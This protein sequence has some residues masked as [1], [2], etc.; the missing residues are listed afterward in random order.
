MQGIYITAAITT[1]LA[2]SI[3]GGAI[4]KKT[5]KKYRALLLIALLAELPMSASAFYFVRIP[6]NRFLVGWLGE[7]SQLYIYLTTLYAPVT[8]ELAKIWPIIIPA[9]YRRINA[10]NAVCVAMAL[11]LGFGIGEIWFLAERLSRVPDIARLPWYQ[12]GGFIS[13]RFMVCVMHGVFT[14]V[15][16]KNLRHRFWLGLLGAMALHFLGNLPL[17]IPAQGFVGWHRVTW[18]YMLSFWVTIYFLLMLTLLVFLMTGKV[19]VGRVLLGRVVCP[20]CHVRYNRPLVGINMGA[21]RYERCSHC[22]KWHWVR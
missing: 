10:R 9:F 12:L 14:A 5:P 8:E 18:Q 1:A 2:L 7:T 17:F 13:E 3:I 21:V 11:G 16:I 15:A 22:R 19:Q 4:W 20:E 6:L